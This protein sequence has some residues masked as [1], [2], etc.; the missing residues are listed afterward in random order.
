[1][2][3]YEQGLDQRAGATSNTGLRLKVQGRDGKLH[4]FV[5][6]PDRQEYYKNKILPRLVSSL[7]AL[8]LTPPVTINRP[9]EEFS[10][11]SAGAFFGFNRDA[12]NL[13]LTWL[14]PDSWL[15]LEGSCRAASTAVMNSMCWFSP[16]VMIGHSLRFRPD[17]RKVAYLRHRRAV[18][19]VAKAFQ[20]R[21]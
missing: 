8:R 20:V 12:S 2:V 10:L 15:E 7:D 4:E 9:A 18:E 16:G 11:G 3:K 14:S 21:S 17:Q 13:V 19:R 6:P 1:M 5:V